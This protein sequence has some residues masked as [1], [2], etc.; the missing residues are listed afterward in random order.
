MSFDFFKHDFEFISAGIPSSDSPLYFD[1]YK[2]A[3]TFTVTLMN[4]NLAYINPHEAP[5]TTYHIPY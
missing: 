5:Y 3:E 2:T 4:P 1:S